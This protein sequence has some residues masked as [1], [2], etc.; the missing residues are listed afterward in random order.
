[1]KIKSNKKQKTITIKFNNDGEMDFL[2]TLFN[3]TPVT[4]GL[5]K[6]FKFECLFIADEIAKIGGNMHRTRELADGIWESPHIQK[7]AKVKRN[8]N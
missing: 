1:M 2:A 3:C 5:R 8:E 6:A 7:I 4:D